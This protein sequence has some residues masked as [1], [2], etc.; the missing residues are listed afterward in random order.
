M[1]CSL[2]PFSC[3]R[4][5]QA[6]VLPINV[7]HDHAERRADAGEGKNQQADQ[8]SVTQ[9]NHGCGVDAVEQLSRFEGP[10]Y[11][12]LPVRT[13]YLGPRTGAA[14]FTAKT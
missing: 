8:C 6:A 12:V 9:A 7:R 14:E 1:V 4:T 11:R 13:T 10:Q 2:P 3:R 5:P